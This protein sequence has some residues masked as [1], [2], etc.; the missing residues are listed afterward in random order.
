M[1]FLRNKDREAHRDCYPALYYPEM[2]LLEG[3]YKVCNCGWLISTECINRLG[4]LTIDAADFEC[5]VKLSQVAH[6]SI[7]AIS[8]YSQPCQFWCITDHNP[9]KFFEYFRCGYYEVNKREKKQ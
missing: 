4:L 5:P 8:L 3:G 6:F 7:L 2:Y 9:A 1:H